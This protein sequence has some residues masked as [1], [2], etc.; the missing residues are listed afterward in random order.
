MHPAARYDTA[1]GASVKTA[2]VQLM[3]RATWAK[4]A[5]ANKPL[6][7]KLEP[8]L[9]EHQALRDKIWTDALHFII[10]WSPT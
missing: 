10:L 7:R 8:Q 9:K 5:K 1:G 3:H 4:R 2:P 6:R